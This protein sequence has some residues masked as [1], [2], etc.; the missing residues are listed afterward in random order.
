MAIKEIKD[1]ESAGLGD[2]SFGAQVR[3]T[4]NRK[5]ASHSLLKA[6]RGI[7]SNVKLL[8]EISHQ[9]TKDTKA[10]NY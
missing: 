10:Y 7:T 6:L 5:N 2:V 1:D 4:D 3:R 8:R 9:D